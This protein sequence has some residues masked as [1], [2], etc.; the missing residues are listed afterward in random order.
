MRELIGATYERN[1]Q[2]G[3][4]SAVS[5]RHRHHWYKQKKIPDA[6]ILSSGTSVKRRLKILRIIVEGARALRRTH[7]AMRL[8]DSSSDWPRRRSSGTAG[9][10]NDSQGNFIA[11]AADSK[12]RRLEDEGE[13]WPSASYETRFY[14]KGEISGS[15][16]TQVASKEARA[17]GGWRVGRTK[18]THAMFP[19]G[20][21]PRKDADDRGWQKGLA[22]SPWF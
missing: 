14:I 8:R 9:A 17:A 7:R 15:E 6:K 11:R 21:P 18:H 4:Y 22:W 2:G 1:R 10:V 20:I 3:E 19:Y 13:I 5:S 12:Y 16:H